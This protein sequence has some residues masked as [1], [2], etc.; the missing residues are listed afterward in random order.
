MVATMVDGNNIETF[1]IIIVAAIGGRNGQ[2][3]E[4]TVNSF[5]RVRESTISCLQGLSFICIYEVGAIPSWF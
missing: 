1:D 2:P 4:V 3:K 5:L